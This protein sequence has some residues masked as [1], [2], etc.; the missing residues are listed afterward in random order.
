[1]WNGGGHSASSQS[2]ETRRLSI[3]LAIAQHTGSAAPYTTYDYDPEYRR[4]VALQQRPAMQPHYQQDAEEHRRQPSADEQ[5]GSSSDHSDDPQE[6]R[7]RPAPDSNDDDDDDEDDDADSVA[8]ADPPPPP[9]GKP[10]VMAAKL[11]AA[12]RVQEKLD[13][14]EK[15][16]D[17]EVVAQ[18]LDD[19]MD[20]DANAE[21]TAVVSEAPGPAPAPKKK[22]KKAT[23]PK[24]PKAATNS[25][26]P[27]MEDPVK[28]ITDVEY[29]NLEALF[30]QF[31]R[32][33]LLAEFSRPVA[34]LH[35]EV[36]EIYW[37]WHCH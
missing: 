35:P 13:E 18:P 37:H 10:E 4:R 11:A 20:V 22:K 32:V 12:A 31:C 33:P 16:E 28:P 23:T 9:R 21:A 2:D 27:T 19:S 8:K 26:I 30:V 1:M 24:K 29:E 6:S 5:A 17:D 3:E 15:D 34:L 14:V 25:A 7:K 36:S